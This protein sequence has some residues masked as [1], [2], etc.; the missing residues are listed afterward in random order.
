MKRACFIRMWNLMM[1]GECFIFFL[2][3]W[4][5]RL[6]YDSFGEV[7]MFDA[8]YETN[9]YN[10]LCA[11]FICINHHWQNTLFYCAFLCDEIASS[12]KWHL[13]I[14]LALWIVILL[15]QSQQTKIKQLKMCS[16]IVVTVYV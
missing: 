11:P 12:F 8:T 7:I 9:K 4:K 10:V 5:I 15:R 13:T 1:I 3:S 16:P 14:F 6:D 2:E